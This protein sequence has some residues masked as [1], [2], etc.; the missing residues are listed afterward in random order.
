MP[1]PVEKTDLDEVAI[2]CQNG[3]NRL[4]ELLGN[5]PRRKSHEEKEKCS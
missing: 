1:P 3:M 4:S 5:H 2:F